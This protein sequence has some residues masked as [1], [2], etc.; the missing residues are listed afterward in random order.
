MCRTGGRRCPG[1]SGTAARAKHNERRRANRAIKRHAVRWAAQH[2]QADE[3]VAGLREA[4]P[5]EV[6][7]WL[8]ARGLDPGAFESSDAAQW[9]QLQGTQKGSGAAQPQGK[10]ALGPD[11]FMQAAQAVLAGKRP[12]TE[13]IRKMAP[14]GHETALVREFAR[15]E[16][17]SSPGVDL[18]ADFDPHEGFDERLRVV[19]QTSGAHRDERSLISGA[20]VACQSMVDGGVNTTTRVELDNGAVGYHKPFDGSDVDCGMF[21]GQDRAYEQGMHEVAAWRLAERLGHPYD[22]IVPPVVVREIDGELGSFALERPGRNGMAGRAMGDLPEASAAAFFDSLIGQ[23]DRHAGNYLVAGDRVTL[24]DHGLSFAT[25]GDYCN[26]SR[27]VVARL[28]SAPTLSY[29]ETVALDRLLGSPDLLGLAEIL[30][31]RRAEA[32]RHR[33]ERMRQA[34]RILGPGDY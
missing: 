29:D 15:A 31:P 19:Q 12:P 18:G 16:A 21:Y 2:G 33:A 6:K 24:I 22:Q 27:F 9:P 28:E 13:V 4:G 1:C 5:R 3:V 11:T 8:E 34:G 25:S 10:G 23:Q 7:D 30:S 32:L 17:G 26:Q 14:P 20:A